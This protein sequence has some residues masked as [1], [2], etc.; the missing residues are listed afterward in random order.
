MAS[1]GNP[2]PLCFN[3]SHSNEIALCAITLNRSIGIDI[4][5]IHSNPDLESIA[6][7]YFSPREHETINSFSPDQRHIAFY[8]LW[9][10][11]E[12]Y[13]KATGE[14]IGGL[15]KVEF[16]MSSY[17]PP[18]VIINKE[19]TINNWTIRQLMPSQGYTF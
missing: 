5:Y 7:H 16:S 13:L 1:N 4:E 8:D 9:T 19:N 14:G 10:L 11:K 15:G 17:D 12:A 3:L 6:E 2:K 18:Q